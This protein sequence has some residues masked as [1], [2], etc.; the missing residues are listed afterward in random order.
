MRGIYIASQFLENATSDRALADFNQTTRI[1]YDKGGEW[2]H[3]IAPVHDMHGHHTHCHWV[4]VINMFCVI[5]T[6]VI[7]TLVIL[8]LVKLT[9][10][11]NTSN[12][13]TS[14]SNTSKTH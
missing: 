14:I 4:C 5:L 11:S 2:T 1:T 6:L 8:T 13:N 10:N 3:I 9:S 7:L 12:S